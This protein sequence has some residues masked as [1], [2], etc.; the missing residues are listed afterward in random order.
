MRRLGNLHSPTPTPLL[1]FDRRLPPLVQISFS[2]QP[3][4]AIKIKDGG[5]D[6]REENTELSLAK[7]T[8]TLQ[9]STALAS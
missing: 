6:F 1:I 4:A 5:H 3:S 9:A 8:P 7:I 2:R